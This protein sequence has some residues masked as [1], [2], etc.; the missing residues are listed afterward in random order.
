MHEKLGLIAGKWKIQAP[1]IT[2]Q[3]PDYSQDMFIDF[4]FECPGQTSK[5]IGFNATAICGQFDMGVTAGYIYTA[6]PAAIKSKPNSGKG[7][8]LRVTWRGR[9]TGEG[10]IE[11]D[12]ADQYMQLSFAETG[13]TFKGVAEIPVAGTVAVTGQKVRE[14]GAG[15]NYGASRAFEYKEEFMALDESAWYRESR[16]RWH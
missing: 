1:Y 13:L 9:E 8:S 7:L 4:A 10:Q 15:G 14:D 2:E 11:F 5:S 3:W 6:L 16:S 12:D